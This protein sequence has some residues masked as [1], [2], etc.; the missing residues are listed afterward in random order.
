[1]EWEK[2]KRKRGEYFLPRRITN[3]E[4]IKRVK[5]LVGDEYTFLDKYINNKTKIRIRHNKCKHIYK[6]R[7]SLFFSGTRCPYCSGNKAMTNKDFANQVK[8]LIGDE[9]TF[10]DKYINANT[11]IRVRHNKCGKSYLVKPYYFLQG[12][13]R[14][15]YCASNPSKATNDSFN[16]K[17]DK[18]FKREYVVLEPYLRNEIYIK[19]KH[20]I[21]GNVYQVSPKKILEGRR[22][23]YCYGTKKERS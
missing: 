18:E 10:L 16:D 1:M 20:K 12:G 21:C 2:Q 13:S 17:L 11:K 19:V 4:F 15:F 7:P 8:E 9:Y 14:C 3:E 22:C 5:E 23:P 6:V